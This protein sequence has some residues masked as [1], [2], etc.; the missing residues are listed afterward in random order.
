MR[1]IEQIKQKYDR[2]LERYKVL[3]PTLHEINQTRQFTTCGLCGKKVE[4]TLMNN[5]MQEHEVIP[6]NNLTYQ[7]CLPFRTVN[8]KLQRVQSLSSYL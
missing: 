8:G 7:L 5:H 4:T 1:Q 2:A 3:H 6:P